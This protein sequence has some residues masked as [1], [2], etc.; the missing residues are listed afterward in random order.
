DPVCELGGG[1]EGEVVVGHGED[2]A[3]RVDNGSG[4]ERAITAVGVGCPDRRA[5]MPGWA[6]GNARSRS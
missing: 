2:V 6:G 5:A 4:R 3:G 1:Q